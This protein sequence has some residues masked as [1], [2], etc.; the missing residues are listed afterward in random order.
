MN[1]IINKSLE[2]LKSFIGLF[3]YFT[4]NIL[5]ALILRNTKDTN[6]Y[7]I[8]L[9]A[10]EITLLL[11]L[12]IVYR[13][14]LKKD[15]IDFDKNYKEYLS[16]GIK[17][18]LIG[19]LVMA[20]SNNIIYRFMDTAYNQQVNELV[21]SKLPLYSI[22]AIVM[23]GPFVEEMVF[24]LS[25]HEHIKNK[26]V[27][28]IITSLIFAGIHVLNGITSPLEL[29]YFIPYGSLALSF[30]IILYKT[31]NIFTTVIL[32]TF[33]NSMAIFMLALA[34]ILGV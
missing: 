13:K 14:R 21:I 15:F 29:L 20:I 19:L 34:A 4:V 3:I 25:F 2:F 28:L 1:N 16:Y 32:H 17:V 18:W 5:F 31:N 6:F 30:G 8:T 10:S 33:H 22:I 23:C 7:Y 9:I 24:R 26:H 27:F 12:I 11:I